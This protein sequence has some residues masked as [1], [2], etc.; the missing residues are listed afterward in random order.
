M[1]S[2]CPGGAYLKADVMNDGTAIDCK[3]EITPTIRA[4]RQSPSS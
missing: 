1:S 2:G 4:G 3:D